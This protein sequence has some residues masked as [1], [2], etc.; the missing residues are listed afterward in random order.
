MRGKRET[1]G[2]MD[3]GANISIA[4][5]ELAE[6]MGVKIIEYEEA[7]SIQFGKEGARSEAI[8]YANFGELIGDIAIVND[9]SDTL[10]HIKTFTDKGMRVVFDRDIVQI[11]D[12]EGITVIEGKC[13]E[14]QL[15]YIDIEEAMKISIEYEKRKRKR[16]ETNVREENRQERDKTKSKVYTNV[17][18][19]EY[20]RKRQKGIAVVVES[21]YESEEEEEDR[22]VKDDKQEKEKEK[23]Q[24][25]ETS[26]NEESKGKEERGQDRRRRSVRGEKVPIEYQRYVWQLHRQCNHMSENVMCESIQQWGHQHG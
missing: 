13:D 6:K 10:I 5:R 22:E 19:K 23:D 11:V 1:R 12:E 2:M 8:G 14:S 3:S 26:T 15:Y 16:E 20:A 21:D 7:V 9:A 18:E 24:N 17:V 4:R 25:E